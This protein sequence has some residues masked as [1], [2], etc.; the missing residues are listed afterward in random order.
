MVTVAMH[1]C[2]QHLPASRDPLSCQAM[3]SDPGD[4]RSDTGDS[5][6]DTGFGRSDTG[7]NR[8][9]I[10]DGRSDT[11]NGR[12]DTGENR[13]DIRDG[14]SDPGDNRSDT[15]DGRSDHEVGSHCYWL[16]WPR[17]RG[18]GKWASSL[19]SLGFG[20]AGSSTAAACPSRHRWCKPQPRAPGAFPW[21]GIW[22]ELTFCT[23]G[24]LNHFFFGVK[25]L[26]DIC[27]QL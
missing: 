15:G 27:M 4:S 25:T 6:F 8:S 14:R 13:S 7:D 16:P 2:P 11:G 24:T 9:D 19:G 17:C 5:I 26:W 20:A 21:G 12:S 22:P 3:G 23:S 18:C 1:S 10:G